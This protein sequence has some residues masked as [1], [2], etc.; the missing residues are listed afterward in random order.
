MLTRGG[1]N[2]RKQIVTLAFWDR[3]EPFY[4]GT[5]PHTVG[6][7]SHHHPAGRVPLPSA[8]LYADT[9]ANTLE[10]G[11]RLPHSVPLRLLRSA[12]YSQWSLSDNGIALKKWKRSTGSGYSRGQGQLDK[13]SR[14]NY[15]GPLSV[16]NG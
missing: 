14:V 2:R 9:T 5:H 13:L 6:L 4:Y 16:M 15:V 11:Y 3:Q 1:Q 8:Y 7:A 12:K 10:T